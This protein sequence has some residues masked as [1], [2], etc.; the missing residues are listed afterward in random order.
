[1]K[2]FITGGT[3]FVGSYLTKRLT[4]RVIRSLC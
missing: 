4:A 1:M 3:G 2:I